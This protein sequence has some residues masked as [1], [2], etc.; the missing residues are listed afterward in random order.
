MSRLSYGHI[1]LFGS[2]NHKLMELT[3]FELFIAAISVGLYEGQ[4]LRIGQDA[5]IDDIVH[6]VELDGCLLYLWYLTIYV[7]KRLLTVWHE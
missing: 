2:L 6:V 4:Y 5:L 1:V 7:A 3:L